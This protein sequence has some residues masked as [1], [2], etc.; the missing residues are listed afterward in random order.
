VQTANQLCD[1]KAK[2]LLKWHYMSYETFLPNNTIKSYNPS[3][4]HNNTKPPFR[5]TN[6]ATASME[7]ST[8]NQQKRFHNIDLLIHTTSL[9]INAALEDFIHHTTILKCN[10]QAK[11]LL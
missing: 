7:Q 9:T 3:S 11:M 8:N 1:T 2:Q 4:P 5:N 10:N 6:H